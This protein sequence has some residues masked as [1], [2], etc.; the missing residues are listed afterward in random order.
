MR[1]VERVPVS[2]D[3]PDGRPLRI[4]AAKKQALA[5]WLQQEIENAL[6]DRLQLERVWTQARKDYYGV[7]SSE[8]RDI[9]YLK[10]SNRV[11]P[12]AQIAADAIFAT[13]FSITTEASPII[14]V[15]STNADFA[16]HAKAIQERID[17]EINAEGEATSGGRHWNFIPSL[18]H[19]GKDCVKQG[20]G[21]WH[22]EWTEQVIKGQFTRIESAGARIE[23][24][25]VENILVPGG[26]SYD[27]QALPWIAVMYPAG[28][29]QA[30]LH[31]KAVRLGWDIDGCRA[32]GNIQEQ[33]QTRER[34]SRQ[35]GNASRS[36]IY[37]IYR[38]YCCYDI[39]GDGET[40]DL[41]VI[42]NLTGT[43]ICKID[44]QPYD[45]R[46]AVVAHFDIEEYL[47][48]GRGVPT[49]LRTQT[50]IATEAL[51]NWID[52]SFLANCRM[53]KGPAG[54]MQEDTLLAWP[55]RYIATTN[56]EQLSEMKMS[57]V[58]PSL[59]ALFQTAMHLAERASGIDDLGPKTN[60]PIGNRTPGITAMSVLQ[61][62]HQRHTPFF[63][64]FRSAAACMVREC[65]YR[66]QEQLLR[67]NSRL[68]RHLNA[69]LGTENAQL[70][71][72]A[73]TSPDFDNAI[74]IELTVTSAQMNKEAERSNQ[75]MLGQIYRQYVTDLIQGAMLA[76]SPQTPPPVKAILE[77]ALV[78]YNEFMERVLRTFSDVDNPKAFIIDAAAE[79]AQMVAQP[80]DPQTMLMQGLE[81]MLGGQNGNGMA[82]T[83]PGASGSPG[84]LE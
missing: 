56:P 39:D 42:F 27:L 31:E 49:I 67:G 81:G 84:E 12:L 59:P 62:V 17:H 6:S 30:M 34:F 75:I 37:D 25:P 20:T 53:Y 18:Y 77:K 24:V 21:L 57:D 69:V 26:S 72:E 64:S 36:D 8:I 76:S 78:V 41:L 83:A 15:K 14:T 19:G 7:P 32:S 38:V 46:P 1:F 79:A 3:S 23:P 74:S 55:G 68:P 11:A 4:S 50:D 13:V 29:T 10:A 52:N 5:S 44:W 58:Y 28:F 70:Y 47:F 65:L 63:A 43:H 40:E 66:E 9:P 71:I 80:Q 45:H 33:S 48:Y 2:L 22:V 54:A 35:S 60:Q 73:L 61:Q 16:P 82:G 51:N